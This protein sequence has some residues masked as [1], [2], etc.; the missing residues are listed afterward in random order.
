MHWLKY[1]SFKHVYNL[2]KFDI[3]YIS[4]RH[5]ESL[6]KNNFSNFIAKTCVVG[7]QKNSL[8]ETVLLRT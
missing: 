3:L 8:N 4:H 2:H 1:E 6:I 7:T 5:I